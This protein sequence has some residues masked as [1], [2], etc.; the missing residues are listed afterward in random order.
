MKKEIFVPILSLKIAK[1][2]SY[3]NLKNSKPFMKQHETFDSIFYIVKKRIG[4]QMD[5][6]CST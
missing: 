2:F 1:N 6:P 4:I 3:L 5:A